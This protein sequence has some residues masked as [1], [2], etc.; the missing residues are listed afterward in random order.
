MGHEQRVLVLE[1]R[2]RLALNPWDELPQGNF[3]RPLI[4]FFNRSEAG[5]WIL[6]LSEPF[7]A[8]VSLFARR[9]E[10][11]VRALRG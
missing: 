1:N 5:P 6:R 7:G 9:E 4:G 10:M 3:R 11:R 8:D 2:V